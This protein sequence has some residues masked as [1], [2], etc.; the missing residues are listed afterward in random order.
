MSNLELIPFGEMISSN[1]RTTWLI[2]DYLNAESFA[3]IFGEPESMKTFCAIDMGLC[4][5]SGLC[6]HGHPVLHSGPVFYIAGEGFSGIAKR[7]KAWQKK[8]KL[9]E[10]DMPFFVS[11]RAVNMSSP[12]MAMEL[13]MLARS[14]R[15]PSPSC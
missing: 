5:A 7:L 13:L 3:V 11:N 15:Q 10:D 14:K 9:T 12:E 8:Q 2:K 1:N 4:I 6:W